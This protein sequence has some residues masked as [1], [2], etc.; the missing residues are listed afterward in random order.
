ML[1][2]SP[3]LKAL[4]KVP[5]KAS[6]KSTELLSRPKHTVLEEQE[7]HGLHDVCDYARWKTN[8]LKQKRL[9]NAAQAKALQQ[10]DA[11]KREALANWRRELKQ[12]RVT[13]VH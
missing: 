6:D 5:A 8:S 10:H 2:R 12:V 1:A 9:D 13:G 11:A 4:Y 3:E 7:Q